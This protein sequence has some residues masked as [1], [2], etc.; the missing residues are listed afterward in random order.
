MQGMDTEVPCQQLDS[1][2]DKL[3]NLF[4]FFSVVLET[5]FMCL[6][7]AAL[8]LH[9]CVQAVS[10]CRKQGLLWLQRVGFSFGGF[11]VAEHGF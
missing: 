10:S 3:L 2:E 5:L 4:F 6:F 8:G 11:L 1:P 7:V 9:C